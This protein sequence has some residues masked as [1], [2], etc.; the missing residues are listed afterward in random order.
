MRDRLWDRWTT[1]ARRARR[2][3]RRELR[4]FRAW[5]ERTSNLVRLSALVFVPLLVATVT[6]LSNSLETLFSP[7]PATRVGDLHPLLES[8]GKYSSPVRFVAG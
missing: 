5:I 7:V 3:E 6:Y 8:A 1:F 4:E 2:F